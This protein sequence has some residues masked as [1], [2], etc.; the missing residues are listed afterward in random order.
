MGIPTPVLR[1]LDIMTVPIPTPHMYYGAATGY[2]SPSM[3]TA[4]ETLFCPMY[5]PGG[6]P[7]GSHQIAFNVTNA[8]VPVVQTGHKLGLL[9][10]HIET[11][12]APDDLL[13]VVQCL[14]SNC[15]IKFQNGEVKAEG[16]PLASLLPVLMNALAC[17]DVISMPA[18]ISATSLMNTVWHYTSFTDL[19]AGWV[20]IWVNALFEFVGFL[21]GGGLGGGGSRAATYSLKTILG[22]FVPGFGAIAGAEGGTVSSLAGAGVR[23]LGRQ[24][25][26][27]QG[28]ITVTAGG[29]LNSWVA[30]RSRTRAT[31]MA[32]GRSAN[33]SAVRSGWVATAGRSRTTGTETRRGNRA[34]AWGGARTP[35][36]TLRVTP[37]GAATGPGRSPRASRSPAPATRVRR[38]S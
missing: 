9:L 14:K 21:A 28:S 30:D 35:P 19:I 11:V 15:E 29:S 17:T 27:Y 10:P 33:R 20:E 26:G 32:P 23:F 25:F 22:S 31:R 13:T 24:Y 38:T 34:G 1:A 12:P 5:W 6:F 4:L 16:N 37:A 3:G 18:G 2:M 7:T 36:R 8:G